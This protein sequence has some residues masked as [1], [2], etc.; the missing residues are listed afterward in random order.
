MLLKVNTVMTT[1]SY[2]TR[3][4]TYISAL[5][6]LPVSLTSCAQS[7]SSISRI[8]L[9]RTACFGV[10]PIYRVTIY[11]DGLVEF[12]GER[13]VESLGEH[14]TRVN[15]EN[16]Q[17]LAAVATDI[18]FFLLEDEYRVRTEPDGTVIA[19]SDLPSRITTVVKDGQ[20]K[21]VLNYFSGPQELERFELLID[22][23]TG[24]DR[25]IGEAG[26]PAF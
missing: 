7:D 22:E 10:C 26:A 2:R 15:P 23:L 25:W 6:L 9:Q 8:S 19:V 12:Q 5:L 18:E 11:P 14:S 1:K 3:I 17:R 24:T 16:F 21:S 20:E 4:V 13:F